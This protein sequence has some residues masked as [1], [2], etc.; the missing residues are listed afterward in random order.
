ME[1]GWH[2]GLD[3]LGAWEFGWRLDLLVLV[4]R[5]GYARKSEIEEGV[6]C[7]ESSV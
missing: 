7:R 5:R 4:T 1:L 2:G 3:C 6:I